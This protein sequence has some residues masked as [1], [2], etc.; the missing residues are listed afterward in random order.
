MGHEN[1]EKDKAREKK[2][3]LLDSVTLT[4][5]TAAKGTAVALKCYVD[6]VDVSAKGKTKTDDKIDN[7]LRVREKLKGLRFEE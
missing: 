6:L 7:L 3:E 2:G 4:M 1:D 5:G